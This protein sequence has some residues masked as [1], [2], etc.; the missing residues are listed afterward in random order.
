MSTDQSSITDYY[1]SNTEK[2]PLSSSSYNETDQPAKKMCSSED[3]TAMTSV[4]ARLTEKIDAIV[5]KQNTL[6]R[7]RGVHESS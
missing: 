3:L 2:R 1:S 5:E 7:L 4:L 6:G